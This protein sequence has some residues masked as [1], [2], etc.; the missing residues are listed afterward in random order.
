MTSTSQAAFPT[1]CLPAE[2]LPHLQCTCRSQGGLQR[3]PPWHA[4]RRGSRRPPTGPALGPSHVELNWMKV[5][6]GGVGEW[7]GVDM[8]RVGEWR[9][10]DMGVVGGWRRVDMGGVGK[11]RRVDMGEEE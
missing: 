4:I 10:V 2:A 5:G 7:R 8:G 11:W 9:R 3:A 6:T 1:M